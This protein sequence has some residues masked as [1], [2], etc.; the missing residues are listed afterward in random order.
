[1]KSTSPFL[2][3]IFILYYLS[4]YP[5]STFGQPLE[6]DDRYLQSRHFTPETVA[7]V[8]RP[9]VRLTLR[10]RDNPQVYGND[11][12]FPNFYPQLAACT[13]QSNS[14]SNGQLTEACDELLLFLLDLGLL[15]L[16]Y[17]QNLLEIDPARPWLELERDWLAFYRSLQPPL[18]AD[19]EQQ[20]QQQEIGPLV[21]NHLVEVLSVLVPLLYNPHRLNLNF[22]P[23]ETAGVGD[24]TVSYSNL[25]EEFLRYQAVYATRNARTRKYNCFI[26]NAPSR[27]RLLK[28]KAIYMLM[29]GEDFVV[30]GE[31]VEPQQPMENAVVEEEQPQQHPHQD[32]PDPLP[33][34]PPAPDDDE[35]DL[36]AFLDTIDFSGWPIEDDGQNDAEDDHQRIPA[37]AAFALATADLPATL[38]F[39]SEIERDGGQ[40]RP[41]DDEDDDSENWYKKHYKK[42]EMR[43]MGKKGKK[44]HFFKMASFLMANRGPVTSLLTLGFIGAL[45]AIIWTLYSVYGNNSSQQKDEEE[46]TTFSTTMITND[47]V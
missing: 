26:R 25:K 28:L 5:L 15:P 40:K 13:R 19:A 30:E 29:V 17:Y 46:A 20:Q 16:L 1:M 34:P 47:G 37:P 35:P 18:P 7:A 6:W 31:N 39:V 33:P 21:A 27:Y 22:F 42:L 10:M 45:I 41:L 32:Q 9:F 23:G 4:P 14:S 24:A 36:L 2:H 38:P 8:E 12:L 3:L 43:S 11:I 44:S